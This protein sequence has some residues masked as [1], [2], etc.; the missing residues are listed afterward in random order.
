MLLGFILLAA[1]FLVSSHFLPWT[2]FHHEM[3]AAAGAVAIGVDALRG[4]DASRWPPLAWFVLALCA[5]PL[6]QRLGGL[7]LF[8]A[9][10][11]LAVLYLAA[12]ALAIGS[13]A[14]L[15]R[16]RKDELIDGL[17]ATFLFVGLG[18]TIIAAAQWVDVLLPLPQ[19][20]YNAGMNGGQVVAN[21]GQPNQLAACLVWSLIGAVWLHYRGKVRTALLALAA[22]MLGFGIVAT[23]SRAGLAMLLV[24]AVWWAVARRRTDV[25]LKPAA[26][27][28]FAVW[29][30]VLA[31]AWSS[32]SE[33]VTAE[34]VRDAAAVGA[35]SRPMIWRY[36]IEAL[37]E[38]PWLGYGWGQVTV[39]IGAMT[40]RMPILHEMTDYAHNIVLDLLMWNGVPLGL[41]I[42][43]VFGWWIVRNARRI[44]EPAS[45][46]LMAGVMTI[47]TYALVEFPHAY[48]Y[49]LVP[50]GLMMGAVDALNAP[51]VSS[52]WRMPRTAQAGLTAL[53][54]AV[55]VLIAVE[56]IELDGDIRDMR[57]AY[58]GYA[59]QKAPEAAPRVIVLDDLRA[60]LVAA[61]TPMHAK[62][63]DD[64][65]FAARRTVARF[66]HPPL[67]TRFAVI[68]G[69]R[70]DADTAR[71]T[72]DRLCKLHSARLCAGAFLNWR[73]EA[74]NDP[75]L[76]SITFE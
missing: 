31:V 73:D 47:L 57:F 65:Y 40:P 69:R 7:T 21:L 38:S 19:F 61:R 39:G 23:Q 51:P 41:A 48:V 66:P 13:G 26:M 1:S 3:L 11:V 74:A 34:K 53:A 55:T 6:A 70:G 72:M 43:G 71:E 42:A 16:T 52:W 76:A 64:E 20:I 9:D 4:K 63:N 45:A 30:G 59:Q 27:I 22:A 2:G 46:F 24:L 54:A 62:L 68:A 60:F 58:A 50:L 44:R 15:A 32:L 14:R 49:F 56:Y 8:R 25:G 18:S 75:T 36:A 33:L 37:R 29:I 5:V 35:G 10:A 67:L 12:F 17:A 28:L